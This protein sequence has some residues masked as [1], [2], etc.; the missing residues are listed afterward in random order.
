MACPLVD[1]LPELK[2]AIVE[3]LEADSR[4][5][6]LDFSATCKSFRS[7]TEPKVFQ[8]LT[9]KN[10]EESGSYAT[11][12]A[13]SD[14]GLYVR[15]I[16]YR[17]T[18]LLPKEIVDIE[19]SDQDEPLE[20]SYTE[21][22]E[23]KNKERSKF[24]L[25]E[26]LPESVHQVL[27][28]LRQFSSLI[29]LTVKFTVYQETLK[30]SE[31]FLYRDMDDY[32]RAQG[33]EQMEGWRALMSHSYNAIASGSTPGPNFK[34]LVLLDVR[35]VLISSFKSSDFSNLLAHIEHFELQLHDLENGGDI[36]TYNSYLHFCSELDQYFLDYLR[37]A[38]SLRL[39]AAYGGPF[40]GLWT[41]IHGLPLSQSMTPQLRFLHIKNIFVDSALLDCIICHKGTLE[42]VLLEEA[43]ARHLIMT[44]ER[45]FRS[46][47]DSDPQ[48]LR[49]FEIKYAS[50]IEYGNSNPYL[51]PKF[52]D[53]LTKVET[54]LQNDPSRRLFSYAQVDERYGDTSELEV[55]NA[56]RFI[57]GHDQ[58]AWDRLMEI[59]QRNVSRNTSRVTT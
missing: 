34:N 50:K 42:T 36:L 25:E 24:N 5:D 43:H 53:Q 19:D 54:L 33:L 31:D 52:E 13:N 9:L 23:D 38:T 2:L 45:L 1:L 14:R 27:S 35:P 16:N 3:L 29:T 12:L 4:E 28:N 59:I 6:L 39:Q 48:K 11:Q 41:G 21:Q 32:Y 10:T 20:G 7:F 17:A 51:A 8:C 26:I 30:Y 57:A 37:S 56:L 15:K 18:T 44:W 47:A 58:M 55:E 40:G 46:I 22:G 49:G